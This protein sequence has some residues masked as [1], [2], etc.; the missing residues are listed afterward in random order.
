VPDTKSSEDV[1]SDSV[2]RRSE[3]ISNI[4]CTMRKEMGTSNSGRKEKIPVA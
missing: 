4:C 3:I 2:S 1:V